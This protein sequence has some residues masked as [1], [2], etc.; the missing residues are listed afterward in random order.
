M[1][2]SELESM[3]GFKCVQKEY[4]DQEIQAG[5]TSDLLS[6]VMANAEAE[7]VLIT[8]QAHKNTI[9]VAQLIGASALVICNDRP[10]PE[11]MLDAARQEKIA[12]FVST[13][14]Q[15]KVSYRIGQQLKS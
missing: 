6:D 2:I 3:L 11:E 14:N 9:A 8:I 12:I 7:C 10:I 13:E 15:F 1:K 4:A 5:Y